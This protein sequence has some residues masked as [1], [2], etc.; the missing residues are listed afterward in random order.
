[1]AD[2]EVEPTGN[3]TVAQISDEVY[4]GNDLYESLVR[5]QRDEAEEPFH[6]ELLW[7]GTLPT[8]GVPGGF[9][10][11]FTALEDKKDGEALS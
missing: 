3:V 10:G 1:M 11:T 6:A 4:A 9:K 8:D 7:A 5:A 2:A